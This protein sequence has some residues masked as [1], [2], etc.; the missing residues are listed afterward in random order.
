M[1]EQ[2]DVR[3]CPGVAQGCFKTRPSSRNMA[4]IPLLLLFPPCKIGD[5]NW[6]VFA[7]LTG[8]MVSLGA[9]TGIQG[10][11]TVLVLGTGNS[12]E[13]AGVKGFSKGSG[14]AAFKHINDPRGLGGAGCVLQA[15][16][17]R[18]VILST[19]GDPQPLGLLRGRC[20]KCQ[21][22]ADLLGTPRQLGRQEMHAVRQL[23]LPL[24]AFGTA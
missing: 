10:E 1:L 20:H 24:T 23:A 4:E 22:P 11:G 8:L 15:K 13:V 18:P 3:A 7:G 21:L 2:T 9:V 17:R 12:L 19:L 5:S 14:R 16:P 6:S